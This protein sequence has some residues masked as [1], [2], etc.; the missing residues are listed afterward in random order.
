[1]RPEE[2]STLVYSTDPRVLEKRTPEVHTP[3]PEQ[4]QLRVWLER[5]GGGKV[6]TIVRGFQ[7][8]EADLKTLGKMLKVQC[9]VGG[10]VKGGAILIQGDQRKKVLNILASKKYNAKISGG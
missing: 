4:Q 3:P 6:V 8:K 5:K 2:R 9:G 7:G 1:M 10:S